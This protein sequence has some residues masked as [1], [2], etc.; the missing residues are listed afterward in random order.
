MIELTTSKTDSRLSV[1]ILRPV[2]PR[3]GSLL[4]FLL[5]LQHTSLVLSS[6]FSGSQLSSSIVLVS[7]SLVIDHNCLCEL[8]VGTSL[9]KVSLSLLSETSEHVSA[10][11]SHKILSSCRTFKRKATIATEGKQRVSE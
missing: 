2:V 6:Q 5:V 10:Y 9:F 7:L 1:T 11:N 4:G 3:K 8:D